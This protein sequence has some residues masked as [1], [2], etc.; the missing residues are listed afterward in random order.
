M[1]PRMLVGM[2]DSVQNK[3]EDLSVEGKSHMVIW[4]GSNQVNYFL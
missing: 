2:R 1:Y 3:S 4:I